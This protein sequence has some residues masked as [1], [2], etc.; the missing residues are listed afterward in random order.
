MG[1][2]YVPL[3]GEADVV[4]KRRVTVLRLLSFM[5]GVMSIEKRMLLLAYALMLAALML[6][7]CLPRVGA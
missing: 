3:V 1:D 6:R 2:E 5:L 4:K 7:L